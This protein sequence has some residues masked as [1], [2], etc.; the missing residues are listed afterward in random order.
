MAGIYIHIPFCIKKCPYCDFISYVTSAD[1][2][3]VYA[4]AVC[5]EALSRRDDVKELEFDTIYIGGGTPSLFPAELVTHILESIKYNFNFSNRWSNFEIS[6][7]A[8]PD[9]LT[10]GWLEAVR[11][12]GVNRLSIGA[13]D[14][15]KQGLEF[16]ERPHSVQDTLEAISIARD[17][18]LESISLDLMFGIPGQS[19]SDLEKTLETACSCQCHHISCYELTVEPGTRLAQRVEAGDVVMPDEDLLSEMTDLVEAYMESQGL[20]Q[21][22]ISNF[23]MEGH[24]CR[25]NLNYWANGQYIGLGC[26]AVSY[27]HG[28]RSRNT[29]SLADYVRLVSEGQ[30]AAT[31]SE[32]LDELAMLRETVVLGLR[33]NRGVSV[34]GLVDRFGVDIREIYGDRLKRLVQAGFIMEHGDRICL[35]R[36]G[37]RIA[38]SVLSELV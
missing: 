27:I 35:S 33:T 1:T 23:A 37:R 9:S 17:A 36:T 31:F 19:V 28:V 16:L 3:G 38:N 11:R 34:S 7:E 4:E 15:S 14:F 18:G 13:Q 20:K 26:S 5:A 25:H 12:L 21:Y 30:S 10:S 2:F 8:N 32:S 6:I 29:S 24:E 22:E